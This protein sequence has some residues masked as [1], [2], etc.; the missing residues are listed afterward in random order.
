MRK[1]NSKNFNERIMQHL[2]QAMCLSSQ[3]HN[4]YSLPVTEP[5]DQEEAEIFAKIL[6][7]AYKEEIEAVPINPYI[8][9]EMLNKKLQD[10]KKLS[11]YFPFTLK[12]ILTGIKQPELPPGHAPPVVVC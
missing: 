10:G 12:N 1:L 6:T 4:R 3:L 8:K 7:Q 5:M 9:D 2:F 11:S